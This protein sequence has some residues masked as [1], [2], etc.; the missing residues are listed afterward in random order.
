MRSVTTEL[1][2]AVVQPIVR[3]VWLVRIVFDDITVAWTNSY[4][5]IVYNSV[6][7]TATG[8]LGKISQIKEATGIK[9][10][11]VDITLSGIKSEVVALALTKKYINRKVYIY[12][13]VVDEAW[14]FDSTKCKLAFLGSIDNIAGSSG[15][16]PSFTI[17]V[18][19]R[20]A[21]WERS[22]NLKYTD[23]DQ[24]KLYPGDKGMEYIPQLAQKK[25]VW[26]KAKFLPDPR[27]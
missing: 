16:S 5:D 14:N 11:G 18:K 9:A 23:A 22:R 20:L 12:Q 3:W 4:R 21:D 2:N 19:S 17:A 27:D 24:Q 7:Y 13:A 15:N 10:S 26:P 6:S 1:Q 25:I 8:N